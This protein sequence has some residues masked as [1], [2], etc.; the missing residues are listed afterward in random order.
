M[1]TE[2]IL[3]QKPKIKKN[4]KKVNKLKV[5]PKLL[6]KCDITPIFTENSRESNRL[7]NYLNKNKLVNLKYKSIFDNNE[8]EE[9]EKKKNKK[10]IISLPKANENRRARRNRSF[11]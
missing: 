9:E 11:I 6:I 10:R 4:M 3:K 7:Q 2:Y 8:E 1:G 5:N